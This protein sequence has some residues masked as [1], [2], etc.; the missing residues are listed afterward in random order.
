[1]IHERFFGKV[2]VIIVIIVIIIFQK[3]KK[4]QYNILY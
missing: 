3:L 2:M 4:I 1:M